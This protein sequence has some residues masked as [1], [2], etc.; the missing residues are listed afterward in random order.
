M[1]SGAG[2]VHE[3]G[4][5]DPVRVQPLQ[6]ALRALHDGLQ[7]VDVGAAAVRTPRACAALSSHQGWTWMWQSVTAMGSAS[8]AR[9]GRATLSRFDAAPRPVPPRPRPGGP[10]A[11]GASRPAVILAD[12]AP[13]PRR[14]GPG[15]G[16]PRRP[17]QGP[18]SCVRFTFDRAVQERALPPGRRARLRAPPRRARHRRRRRSRDGPRLRPGRPPYGGRPPPGGGGGGPRSRRRGKA[19]GAPAVVTASRLRL[20]GRPAAEPLA[21]GRRGQP[22]A[23]LDPRRVG[24]GPAAPRARCRPARVA[25]RSSPRATR[26]TTGGSSPESGA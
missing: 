18:S 11:T 24:R 23:G 6:E 21:R 14:G 19:P 7:L 1:T 13:G 17:R 9:T 10:S 2:V 25:A 3:H 16:G 26:P 4:A 5:V 8:I 15:D 22:A 20:P 12:P